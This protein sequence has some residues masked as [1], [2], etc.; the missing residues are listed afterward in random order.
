MKRYIIKSI[1]DK[2]AS[3]WEISTGK[4]E[5]VE[6][7]KL[8]DLRK[9][10]KVYGLDSENKI[11]TPFTIGRIPEEA[12]KIHTLS[13][14]CTDSIDR[15]K[16]KLSLIGAEY[17]EIFDDECI[18][19]LLVTTKN[20]DCTIYSESG[21]LLRNEMGVYWGT[22]NR[23]EYCR[24][25]DLSEVSNIPDKKL[26]RLF[27]SCTALEEVI[28]PKHVLKNIKGMEQTFAYTSIKSIDLGEILENS[29]I[30][31]LTG[32]FE[33]CTELK[34]VKGLDRVNT[35]NL[36]SLIK[37][38]YNTGLEELDLNSWNV[39][40][41]RVAH[42]MCAGSENLKRVNIKSWELSDMLM[43]ASN[44]MFRDCRNIE[45]IEC[46]LI[47]KENVFYFL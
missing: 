24:K 18:K 3:L 39:K 17:R 4:I 20:K 6:L 32:C 12:N 38:F 5:N 30:E 33:C 44:N 26:T 9:K 19:A 40:N 11:L 8:N 45:H 47:T 10:H 42:L 21:F 23:L 1:N 16:I 22:F 28:F 36:L 15:L 14:K 13:F 41:L 34:E 25:I 2:D 35:E 29:K 27:Y 43:R 31:S 37:T 46:D 7:D